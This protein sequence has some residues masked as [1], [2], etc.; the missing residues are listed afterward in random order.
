MGHAKL[1][2]F[3]AA[4]FVSLSSRA[5][6]DWAYTQWGMN[7]DQV[8]AA[9]D[10]LVTL[11]PTDKQTRDDTNHWVMA[12]QGSFTDGAVTGEVGFM[13][14][15]KTN[16]LTCVAYNTTG[17]NV[18]ILKATLIKRFGKPTSSGIYG[19]AEM[20]SW[21]KPDKIDYAAGQGP[22]AAVMQCAPTSN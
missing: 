8:A 22:A 21:Q 9:S 13:F 14:D 10:G 3:A 15:T 5:S 6:A 11:I 16:G 4:A 2:A 7:P 1:V 12:A 20:M 17:S 18:A 19:P